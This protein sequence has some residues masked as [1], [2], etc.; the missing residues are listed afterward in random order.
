VKLHTVF[1]RNECILPDRLDL[2]KEPFCNGW[3]VAIGVLASELDASIRRKG[4]H[5]MWLTDTQSSRGFGRTPE[6]AIR[7]ALVNALKR[8]NGRFNAAELGKL[9]ITDCLGLRMAKVTLDT[10]QIQRKT[11]LALAAESRL[12]EVLAL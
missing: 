8:V 9:Q 3:A 2:C 10:R 11:S 4:W 7:R 5:F 6:T 12:Q 1:L